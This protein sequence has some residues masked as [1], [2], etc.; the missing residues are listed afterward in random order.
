MDSKKTLEE[1]G[2][3]FCNSLIDDGATYASMIISKDNSIL[4]SHSTNAVWDGLYHETGY[5]KS[6]HLFTAT[7]LIAEKS[8]NFILF[9]DTVVPNNEISVY[10]NAQREEKNLCHGVSFCKRNNAGILEIVTLAGRKCDLNF[11]NQVMKNKD[12]VQRSLFV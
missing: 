3:K 5:S 4:Y 8:N 12:R 1:L 7:K 11:S 2:F 6:C 10:L 9:W